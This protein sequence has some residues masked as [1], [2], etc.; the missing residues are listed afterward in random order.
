VP[1]EKY[2]KRRKKVC[3]DDSEIENLRELPYLGICGNFTRR[4]FLGISRYLGVEAVNPC[5]EIFMYVF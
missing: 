2:E 3:C 4:A 1:L 5:L